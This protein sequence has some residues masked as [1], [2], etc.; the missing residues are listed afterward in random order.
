MK[1]QFTLR[2]LTA[3][4]LL[5]FNLTRQVGMFVARCVLFRAILGPNLFPPFTLPVV[6]NRKHSPIPWG[7][8][9]LSFRRISTN[10]TIIC[11]EPVVQG[12]YDRGPSAKIGNEIQSSAFFIRAFMLEDTEGLTQDGLGYLCF[13]VHSIPGTIPFDTLNA[14][15]K[16][17]WDDIL[18]SPFRIVGKC[19]SNAWS[20]LW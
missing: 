10:P 4:Y 8:P 19:I 13:Q 11:P 18:F 2:R 17:Q 7:R 3:S 9:D 16:I 20:G 12:L 14:L 15:V 5:N 1:E 6:V